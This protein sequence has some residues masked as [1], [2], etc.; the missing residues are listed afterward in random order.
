MR[1]PLEVKAPNHGC[2]CQASVKV[3]SCNSHFDLTDDSIKKPG[4]MFNC[5]GPRN[6]NLGPSYE[7]V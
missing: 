5:I 1:A 4:K 3:C 6:S 2:L 7:P